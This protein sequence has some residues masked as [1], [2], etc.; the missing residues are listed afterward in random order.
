MG[1]RIF[2]RSGIGIGQA[3]L[4]DVMEGNCSIYAAG[5]QFLFAGS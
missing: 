2:D 4:Q 3:D 5:C 1:T